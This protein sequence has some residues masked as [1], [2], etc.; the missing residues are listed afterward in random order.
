MFRTMFTNLQND[1]TFQFCVI[2]IINYY[3]FSF[4][5]KFWFKKLFI[6]LLYANYKLKY[7]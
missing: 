3:L 6:I 2:S 7:Y 1:V 5:I 4:S